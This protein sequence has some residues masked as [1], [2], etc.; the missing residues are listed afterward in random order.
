MPLYAE[1]R[2]VLYLLLLAA[3]VVLLGEAWRGIRAR[4]RPIPEN[5]PQLARLVR[6]GFR[7]L[8]SDLRGEVVVTRGLEAEEKLG[9][10]RL[11]FSLV[12]RDGERFVVFRLKDWSFLEEG[13]RAVR[14]R[15]L[16]LQLLGDADGVILFSPDGEREETIR[17]HIRGLWAPRRRRWQSLFWAFLL[18]LLVGILL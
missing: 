12:E 18:G 14:D 17:F 7:V 6:R 11:H 15:L 2:P 1:D 9:E 5:S 8:S 3:A 4:L 10:G 16:S 13:G